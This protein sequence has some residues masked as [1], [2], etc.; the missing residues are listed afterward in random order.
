MMPGHKLSLNDGLS[1]T[2]M[3]RNKRSVKESL[4]G[5]M[6]SGDKP[7]RQQLPDEI[8]SFTETPF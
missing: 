3:S 8:S 5:A 4:F 6:I 7:S 2:M 1:G